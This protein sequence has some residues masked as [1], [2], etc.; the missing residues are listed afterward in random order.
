MKI[1]LRFII[2]L[3]TIIGVLALIVGGIFMGTGSL[4]FLERVGI[5]PELGN[6]EIAPGSAPTET[7]TPSGPGTTTVLRFTWR[8]DE[9]VYNDNVVSE[10]EFGELLAAAK[11]NDAKVEIV[12]LS[13]VRVEMAD[14]WRE[15]LDA[16]GVR[17]EI[18][19]QE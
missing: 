3:A 8:G 14:R 7:G 5:R 11:T 1:I 4:D 10:A 2:F 15:M 6:L 12:K 16:A 18:I 9:I 13:D 17:Y 19:P